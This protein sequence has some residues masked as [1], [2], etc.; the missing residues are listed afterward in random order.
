MSRFGDDFRQSFNKYHR[1]LG[2]FLPTVMFGTL[3]TMAGMFGALTGITSGFDGEGAKGKDFSTAE[4]Q[5]YEQRIEEIDRTEEELRKIDNFL[6]AAYEMKISESTDLT[7]R[8]K[9]DSAK[10]RA[11]QLREGFN[12]AVRDITYKIVTNPNLDEGAAFN[13]A[14]KLASKVDG[15]L[16]QWFADSNDRLAF[17]TNGLQECQIKYAKVDPADQAAMISACSGD[18]PVNDAIKSLGGGALGGISVLFGLPLI[19]AARGSMRRWR[20]DKKANIT[21]SRVITKRGP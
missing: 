11:E 1:G 6:Q 13:L 18:I 7:L 14:S 16:P 5:R 8:A 21:I 19:G 4:E 2:Y 9:V 3:G 12:F 20:D 17:N 10:M 15:K